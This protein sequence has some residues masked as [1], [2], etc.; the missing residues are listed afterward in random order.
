M[1]PKSTNAGAL[2]LLAAPIVVIAA[3][4]IQPTLSGDAS[5][6]VTA[7]T[8]H[9]QAMITGLTLSTIALVLLIAGTLALALA[10]AP[11]APRL[12]I[13]GAVLGVFGAL[14]VLFENSVDAAAPAI[15]SGLGHAQ[16][17]A[18]LERV[19]SGAIAAVEPLALLGDIGIA[20]LGIAAL[21][22]GAPR[23][24]A[25]AIAVGALGEGAGFAT[26]T[27]ALVITSFAILFAGLLPAVRT[28]AARPARRPAAAEPAPAAAVS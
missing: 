21:T 8:G 9:H 10:L 14:V 12:A 13:A 27:K 23:W 2:A 19:H 18:M 17:T 24:A 6:Q 4:L 5:T 20:L 28:L 26:S 25:A 15:A 16:A 11:R 3:V 1:F 7:L 22:A